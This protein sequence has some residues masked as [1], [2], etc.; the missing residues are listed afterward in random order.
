MSDTV[1]LA[2]IAAGFPVITTIVSHILNRGQL[3]KQDVT[4]ANVEKLANS[5][6]QHTEQKKDEA[7]QKLEQV[8]IDQLTAAHAKIAELEK[9]VALMTAPIAAKAL[10]PPS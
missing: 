10:E 3:K 2:L 1:W 8:K 5:T 6:L 7:L 9:Q 4:L